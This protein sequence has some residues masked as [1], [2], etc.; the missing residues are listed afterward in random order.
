MAYNPI[1][2]C[3]SIAGHPGN[4]GQALKSI[5][6]YVK[7]QLSARLTGL[8]AVIPWIDDTKLFMSLG[9][10]MVTH[11]YYTGLY[12][13]DDMAF[14]LR[15]LNKT[16]TLVDIGANAGVFSILAA[17]VKKATVVAYEPVP[18]TYERLLRNVQ[19]NGLSNSVI[20]VNKGLSGSSGELCFTTSSDA[21]NHVCNDQEKLSEFVKVSVTTLDDEMESQS[22]VPSV[23]KIDVEGYEHFVLDGASR[24]LFNNSTNIILIELNNSGLRY[25]YSDQEIANKIA[26]F[27][28]KSYDY[29]ART[30]ILRPTSSY[31]SV[32]QNTLFIRNIE[33][34]N[35]RIKLEQRYYIHPTDSWV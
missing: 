14:L 2:T 5:F 12:E 19:L 24:I 25:G 21:T 27:G 1:Q 20:C 33:S 6:R 9:E 30:N 11:N 16:D 31:K 10:A 26:S 22:V 29:C 4:K 23:L 32:R 18:Q 7:W 35:C 17:K 15:Y 3:A 13:Y 28:F 34:V 8:T